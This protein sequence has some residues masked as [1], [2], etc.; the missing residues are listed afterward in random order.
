M[1]TS[2]TF[3]HTALRN[4]A[5]TTTR[6]T[7]IQAWGELTPGPPWP[8]RPQSWGSRGPR[9]DCY[10][11]GTRRLR[12][13][14]PA[15]CS[16]RLPLSGG[17][18]P[19]L[20]PG[21]RRGNSTGQR[22]Q[23][24]AAA[25]HLFDD[26]VRPRQQRGRDREAEGFGGLEVDD[27]LELGGLLDGEV[28]RLGALEDLVGVDGGTPKQI[29]EVRAITHQPTRLHMIP[30]HEECWQPVPERQLGYSLS[31][32]HVGAEDEYEDSLRVLARHCQQGDFQIGPDARH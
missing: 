25:V 2:V 15:A 12:S 29:T 26:P 18:R 9:E 30:P 5:P 1:Y 3:V 32:G 8:G 6:R 24:E 19:L 11:G 16:S 22:R 10:K 4:Q 13:A 27:Q 23:E 20:R 31:R 28:G 14:I 21:E 7:A 17:S